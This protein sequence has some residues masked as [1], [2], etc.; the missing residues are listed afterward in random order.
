MLRYKGQDLTS[1]SAHRTGRRF[2]TDITDTLGFE[3]SSLALAA[4]TVLLRQHS[5][6]KWK[7]CALNILSEV[8]HFGDGN[9]L[10]QVLNHLSLV[11]FH[12]GRPM[13]PSHHT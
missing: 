6:A 12:Q 2:N 8:S 9:P 13:Q 3:K 11:C 4:S 1:S 7:D 5:H 10:L